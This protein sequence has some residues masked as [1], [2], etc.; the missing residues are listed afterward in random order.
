MVIGIIG[1]AFGVLMFIIWVRESTERGRAVSKAENLE[2]Y[3]SDAN[4]EKDNF[5]QQKEDCWKRYDA[6]KAECQ[7]WRQRA[8]ALGYTPCP[9]DP[10][11]ED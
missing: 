3:L 5:K 9:P 6:L 2:G 11:D 10:R 8:L 7:F 4:R 1:G